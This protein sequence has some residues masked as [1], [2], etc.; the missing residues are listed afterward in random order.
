MR[1]RSYAG[2]QEHAEMD[3]GQTTGKSGS[4][5]LH[6]TDSIPIEEIE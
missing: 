4:C 2:N 1:Q 5:L 3:T 6:I